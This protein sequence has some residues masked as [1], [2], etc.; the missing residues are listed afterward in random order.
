M[1]CGNGFG[2]CEQAI[3]R[4]FAGIRACNTEGSIKSEIPRLREYAD[5]F[6][7][8]YRQHCDPTFTGDKCL[9]PYRTPVPGRDGGSTPLPGYPQS[10][11]KFNGRDFVETPSFCKPLPKGD[12]GVD[13]SPAAL[14]SGPSPT[15]LIFFLVATFLALSLLRH[16]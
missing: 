11:V 9:T 14:I 5:R 2:T 6:Q 15:V 10:K 7:K 3:C 1:T 8:D 13:D 12:V 4:F 16:D